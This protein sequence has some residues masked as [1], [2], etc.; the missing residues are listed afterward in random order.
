MKLQQGK[1]VCV[2]GHA[3]SGKSTLLKLIGDVLEPEIGSVFVSSHMSVLHYTNIPH[4]M[5]NSIVHNLQY[6][7]HGCSKEL[8]KK[9]CKRLLL[10]ERAL[11]QLEDETF[12][13]GES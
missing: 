5:D 1:M 10:S 11:S 7:D 4:L 13:V 12:T 6:G 2:I 3:H 8:M 9:V